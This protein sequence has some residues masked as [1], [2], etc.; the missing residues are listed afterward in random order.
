MEWRQA[1]GQAET[2]TDER[3]ENGGGE[4]ERVRDSVAQSRPCHAE[5]FVLV[6]QRKRYVPLG[7]S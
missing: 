3:R 1:G 5:A 6:D 7:P 2:G 4:E